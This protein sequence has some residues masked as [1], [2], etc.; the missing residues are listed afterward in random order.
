MEKKWRVMQVLWELKVLGSKLPNQVKGCIR[1][2]GNESI[3]RKS[4]N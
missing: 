3:E 2:G 4:G 1:A